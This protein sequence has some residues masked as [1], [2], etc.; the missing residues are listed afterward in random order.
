MLHTICSYA[1]QGSDQEN[2]RSPSLSASDFRGSPRIQKMG[3]WSTI[4]ASF[5]L[6]QPFLLLTI[7]GVHRGTEISGLWLLEVINAGLTVCTASDPY[8]NQSSAAEPHRL[9]QDRNHH[10]DHRRL[11][12]GQIWYPQYTQ[13]ATLDL[14]ND[15]SGTKVI[16]HIWV[17]NTLILCLFGLPWKSTLW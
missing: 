4:F 11:L 2:F 5:R 14:R 17:F 16:A 12:V 7:L 9:R 3:G 8:I 1:Q 6:M 10:M 13:H 15:G